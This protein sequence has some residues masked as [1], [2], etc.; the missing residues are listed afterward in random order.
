[1]PCPPVALAERNDSRA[2]FHC[3][4]YPLHMQHRCP[5]CKKSTDSD[6][7]A[8][9]PFCSERCKLLDLGAWA[10]EKYVISE[11]AMDETLFEDMDR[12]SKDEHKN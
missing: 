3:L 2:S 12:Q 9:F 4:R 11:P 1:M 7:N 6:A 8:E 10:S 5:I